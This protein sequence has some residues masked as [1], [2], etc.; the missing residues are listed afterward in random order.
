MM[1]KLVAIIGPTS[2]GKSELALEIA[3]RI[4]GEI[5]SCDSVQLYQGL[6]IGSGKLLP[7]QMVSSQ[8][9]LI[10]HHM[11]DLVSAK[12]NYTVYDY[13]KQARKI[14]DRLNEEQK[15]VLLC[16]GTGLYFN[17]VVDDYRFHKY[18]KDEQLKSQLK[19]DE[20][21]QV[22][23]QE[24]LHA[25]LTSKDPARASNIHPNNVRRVVSALVRHDH[26]FVEQASSSPWYQTRIYGINLTRSALYDKINSRV[27][28]MMA[29]GLL[30]ETKLLI[31]QGIRS[32]SKAMQSLGY[33]HMVMFLKG[34]CDLAEAIRLMKRDTRHFAKKQMTWF[35]RDPRIIWISWEEPAERR[36]LVDRM[37]EEII[38]F[39]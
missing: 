11:I 39:F 23:G 13:Q 2:S 25:L 7:E 18:D 36:A 21:L 8:G 38:D 6:D 22:H 14:I 19:Y 4:D 34:K 31:E 28:R 29:A 1:K 17:A 5:V 26:G 33:R 30:E 35:K 16:G 9:K 24:A 10:R 32:D 20:Y 3:G 37:S 15:P 12:K 27:D